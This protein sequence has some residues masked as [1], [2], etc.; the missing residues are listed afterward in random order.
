LLVLAV[1][2]VALS[3]Q[4]PGKTAIPLDHFYVTPRHGGN[5]FRRALRNV[6]FGAYTGFGDTFFKN[7]VSGF[8]F[9]QPPGGMPELFTTASTTAHRFTNW[10]N[11]PGSDQTAPGS[12]VIRNPGAV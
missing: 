10:I 3:A 2:P 11:N 5:I 7:Q 6:H 4:D 12:Y 8:G 9:Y 1:I